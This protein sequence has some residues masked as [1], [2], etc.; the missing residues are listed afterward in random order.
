MYSSGKLARSP[1]LERASK[2][3]RQ[4]WLAPQHTKPLLYCKSLPAWQVNLIVCRIYTRWL[5]IFFS[6][7]SLFSGTM[8]VSK[9]GG[10]LWLSS[11]LTSLSYAKKKCSVCLAVQSYH[12]VLVG[13]EDQWE[14]LFLF[15]RPL[16][17]EGS[18]KS[19]SLQRT[20]IHPLRA[21]LSNLIF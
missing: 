1:P 3:I 11:S 19:M 4:S 7:S 17:K 14:W 15:R 8:K 20:I 9:E 18:L 5:M 13:K 6:T 2:P 12:Q 10:S 21:H 16:G